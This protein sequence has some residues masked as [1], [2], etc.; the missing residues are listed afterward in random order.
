MVVVVVGVVQASAKNV[1][2]VAGAAARSIVVAEP[3]G[4][5]LPNVSRLSTVTAVE[6]APAVRVWA[7]EVMTRTVGVAGVMVAFWV[8]LV[9]PPA[10]AVIRNVPVEVPRK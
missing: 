8:A 6:Q 4:D 7:A 3:T 2:P 5:G 10:A 9:K 1:N